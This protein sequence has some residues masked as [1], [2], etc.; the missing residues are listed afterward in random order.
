M[1][2]RSEPLAVRMPAHRSC[3]G[4]NEFALVGWCGRAAGTDVA[5]DI[6]DKDI[7]DLLRQAA[8]AGARCQDVQSMHA[9]ETEAMLL[10]LLQ[11]MD[12]FERVL[13]RIHGKRDELD[14]QVKKWVGNFRTIHRMLA[15]IL[16]DCG[17]SRIKNVEDGFDPRYHTASDTV[18]DPS[19]ADGTILDTSCSG[20]FWRGKV[21]RK[22]EVSVVRNPVG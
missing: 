6:L 5:L 2:E 19:R 21:L 16:T 7:G 14:M 13:G 9:A 15:Q 12:A 4:E 1:K 18:A 10:S 8:D 11:V 17:V 20:Y 3:T 22:A